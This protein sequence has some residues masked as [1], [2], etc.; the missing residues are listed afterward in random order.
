MSFTKE[1]LQKFDGYLAEIKEKCLSCKNNITQEEYDKFLS[2]FK[3]ASNFLTDVDNISPLVMQKSDKVALL[4]KC[5]EVIL[6]F[7][8]YFIA[9]RDANRNDRLK[10]VS[11]IKEGMLLFKGNDKNSREVQHVLSLLKG[12]Y[13][14]RF[15]NAI[16]TL[17]KLDDDKNTLEKLR[18]K[19]YQAKTS[20]ECKAILWQFNNRYQRI[21]SEEIPELKGLVASYCN[22]LDKHVRIN[23]STTNPVPNSVPKAAFF[24]KKIDQAPKQP[25]TAHHSSANSVKDLIRKF[26]N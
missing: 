8:K 2:Y 14:D 3:E 6:I 21:I 9:N 22:I 16:K 13:F 4:A 23:S 7:T 24:G 1:S 10:N 11:I 20:V 12:I 15:E 25:A 18:V 17:N 5:D 26:N 19:F